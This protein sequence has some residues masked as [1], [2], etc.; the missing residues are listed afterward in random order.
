M[1]GNLPLIDFH[2]HILPGADHGSSGM[3]ESLNQL[4]LMHHVGVDTVVATPHFYPN[5]HK[6]DFF[7]SRVTSSA[8]KIAQR[9]PET[10]QI[11]VGAEVLYCDGLNEMEHLDRLCIRGTDLL[12]LEL[13]MD[14][15]T[16]EV[17]LTIEALLRRYR[18]ILAHIDRYV[19]FQAE[20]IGI[21]L[22]MGALAQVNTDAFF[23]FTEKR[24]IAPFLRNG[25]IVAL[26]SDL[27][28][29]NKR[30]Y[31][32]FYNATRRLG[33]ETSDIMRRSA[34]LLK[35]AERI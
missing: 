13:P 9:S 10:P 22:E 24:K 11:C 28:N 30:T 23:S 35:N 15:W 21:F 16:R 26:G 34:E 8:E 25:Q 33:D 27:H 29:A 17:F 7:L 12:L 4:A 14:H 3:E 18:V 6:L 20:E 19:R 31:E 32:R 5:Q 2:A 1:S